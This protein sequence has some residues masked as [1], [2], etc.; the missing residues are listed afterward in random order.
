[1]EKPGEFD[2]V[3][4]VRSANAREQPQEIDLKKYARLMYK[5]RYAFVAVM[6]LVTGI[7]VAI[8]YLLPDK[9]EAASKVLIEGNYAN[10]ALK[11]V[12]VP[13][14]IDDRVKAVEIIMQSR[15]LVLKAL[16]ELGYAPERSTEGEVA[17]LVGSFQR[18]TKVTMDMNRSRRN[19]D[20]FSVSVRHGNPVMARDYVNALVRLYIEENLSSKRDETVGTKKFLVEQVDI[21]RRKINAIEA[22]SAG[23]HRKSGTGNL[24]LKEEKED[25]AQKRLIEVQNRLN[26]LLLQYTPQH[27]EVEKI[28]EELAY[29]EKQENR[30]A[31][32]SVAPAVKARRT[33]SVSRAR[34]D[35]E[36]R[37]N[38]LERD[39]NS[40]QKM[41]EEMLVTLGK[42]EVSS[43]LEVQ[44]KGVTFNVIEPA[45]LPVKPVSPDR[46]LI[47]VLGFFAG[48]G[49]AMV[50]V[51]RMDSMDKSIKSV[52][53]AKTFG[54][55]VLAV[56]PQIQLPRETDRAQAMNLLLF[57]ITLLYVEG[58]A[59]LLMAS[60]N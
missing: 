14:M 3:K 60:M 37:L 17:G 27:P 45:V 30:P 21:L 53:A 35:R 40:Y 1:M 43:S 16:K 20:M 7:I 32:Q 46:A 6:I 13:A 51:I 8:G 5:K 23:I 18:A 42:S 39:R 58:I 49:A 28:R 15:P 59:V 34:A 54:H 44:D 11:D 57:I 36:Q 56:F 2:V 22:E 26:Q 9:Y 10:D 31:M 52:E 48:V 33:G 47:I 24:V 12:A 29:L 25:E 19:V 38:E 41:Y 4:I 55:P 50:F